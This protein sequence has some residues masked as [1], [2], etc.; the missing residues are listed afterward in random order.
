MLFFFG[1][2]TEYSELSENTANGLA[3]RKL[4]SRIQEDK[5]RKM[6]TVEIVGAIM[7]LFVIAIFAYNTC[8]LLKASRETEEL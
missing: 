3:D 5:G 7:I 6:K 2:S 8:F 4:P 1:I